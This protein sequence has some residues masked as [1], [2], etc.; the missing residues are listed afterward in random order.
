[1]TIAHLDPV[2][3]KLNAARVRGER[4]IELRKAAG[5]VLETREVANCW[6]SRSHSQEGGS[7]QTIALPKGS[8][9][10]FP[11][12]QFKDGACR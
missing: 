8:D 11:T 7:A 4:I 6:A 5:P 9:R 12:F 1:M 10:V 2:E 3:Q